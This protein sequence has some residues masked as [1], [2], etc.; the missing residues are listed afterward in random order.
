MRKLSVLIAG[1]FWAL[2]FVSSRETASQ[3][4]SHTAQAVKGTG[5]TAL[6]VIPDYGKMPL[7]FIPNEGQLDKQVA[8]YVQGKDRTLF[9]T[10][11]GITLALNK[12]APPSEG[13]S[14]LDL[15]GSERRLREGSLREKRT[16]GPR[17][18]VK[19]EFAGAAQGVKP[20]GEME[21]GAVVSYFKGKRDKWRTGL[22]TYSRIVYRNLWP[23][24]DL[25]YHGTA[26][27]LKYEFIVQPGADPSLIRLTYRGATALAIDESGCLEVSTPTGKLRDDAPIAYQED[28]GQKITVPIRYK[29]ALQ[30]MKRGGGPQSRRPTGGESLT[31]GFLIGEYDPARLLVLDPALLVYCG[32]L[33]GSNL[34]L[35]RDVAVDSAGSAYV[36]G[37]TMSSEISFP[38]TTGPDVSYNGTKDVFV[39]KVSPDG[40]SLVYC[41]YIGGASDDGA[42]AVAVDTTGNAYVGGSTNS[43]ESTFPVTIGPGLTYRGAY[44]GF[45]AK[46]N[47][48]GTS[49]VYCGYIGG[50]SDDFVHSICVDKNSNACVTGQTKSSQATF[51][52]AVGPGLTYT[53]GNDIFVAKVSTSGTGLVYCGYIGG[54]G[55]EDGA[56]IAVDDSGN[57]YV[58][59]VTASD[60]ATFPVKVG[61]DLTYNGGS[62]DAYV[63]KA[64]PLGTGLIYCGYVGGAGFENSCD[65]AVNGTE[66]VYLVGHTDS[67]QATFPVTGGPDLTFNGGYD[68]YVGK[69]NAA[70]TGLVY[71]GYLGG[72]NDDLCHNNNSIAIDS[73]G[74]AYVLGYTSSN[75]ASFPVVAGP[76]L[77]HNGGYDTFV[78]KV[79]LPGDQLIYCGYIGGAGDDRGRG[80]AVDGSGNAYV[81]G[82]THST[83]ASFPVTVGPDLTHNG[84]ED[85][86]AA[87]IYY[88][89]EGVF[90]HAVGDFDGCGKD[91]I[92]FDFGAAGAWIYDNPSW[93]QMTASNPEGLLAGDVDGDHVDE[94]LAD[95]GPLGFWLRNGGVWNQL[96][97]V[98]AESAAVGDV[99][100]DGSDEVVGDFGASGLWLLNG[101]VW[102][103]LSGLNVDQIT[104]ANADGIAADEIVGDFGPIGLWIW[105]T[106]VWT[107]L[108]GVNAD[109]LT[110]G[111]LVGGH[112]VVGD[113]GATG[114]W[115]WSVSGGW[116]QL[117]GVNADYMITANTNG[118]ADDEI[119]GDFGTLGLW[120][121]LGGGWS[122]TSGVNAEYLIRVDADGDGKDEIA[123]DFG[124]LGL[125]L[126]DDGAWGQLSGVNPEYMLAGDLDGDSKDEIA[127]D[128]GA[129]GLW[130]WDAGAWSQISVN[131][132][133]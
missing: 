10:A 19:L 21:T 50:S 48:S 40:K 14:T 82:V 112:Y 130:V 38:V 39:A 28:E 94:I 4:G 15:E 96:S 1:I 44:D 131:N 41:G 20:V 102:S 2:S 62:Y 45:V 11:E 78:A 61:P 103:Q 125:W 93:T 123:V 66:N 110:F 115:L 70:G 98:N 63:A 97:G 6:S 81:T 30:E 55:D 79:N 8:F 32:Y 83:E 72:S 29:L 47:A 9:F 71:C 116:T 105:N 43:D 111:K 73:M 12:P 35:A 88:F 122:Q 46:V 80:I 18:V 133:E 65:V 113:F 59:G 67:T 22:P 37:D 26:D 119:V 23:G 31:Y 58:S 129:L 33:G 104:T 5:L 51:P 52:V 117:S 77:S 120:L 89:D 118:D 3:H 74:N 75:E 13:F 106:G 69:I 17:S 7:Y 87:K 36:V 126:W 101:G 109:Y 132:P 108:S 84:D 42:F 56:G 121:S 91:E 86:F 90:R 114:L 85:A 60:E 76:D 124:S 34:D 100:A 127:T 49:L 24:I 68:V 107:Q 92:A 27:R 16:A 128:F 25:V 53:A 57:A 95:L 99:D 64:D 54:S